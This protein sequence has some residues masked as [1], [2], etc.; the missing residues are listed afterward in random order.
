MEQF[1]IDKEKESK[2]KKDKKYKELIINF[3]KF[4]KKA[5]L[6]VKEAYFYFSKD[7]GTLSK[8]KFLI[9]YQ[10]LGLKSTILEINALYSYLD[11]GKTGSISLQKW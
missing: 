1:I 6:D 7:T 8:N 2:A 9:S 4:L 10:S 5:N 3:L 11:E